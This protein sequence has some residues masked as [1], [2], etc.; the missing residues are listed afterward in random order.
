MGSRCYF[1]LSLLILTAANALG[2]I[3]L[4]PLDLRSLPP[5]SLSTQPTLLVHAFRLRGNT[6]F[7]DAQLQPLLAP[8]IGKRI[9]TEQLEDGRLAL[10]RFYVD[11][12]YINSGAVLSD[13]TV[14][15]G[16]VTY[17][18]IEGRLSDIRLNFVN[19]VGQPTPHLLRDHYVISR[20]RLGS[21]GPLNLI[22]LKDQLE[23]LRQDP[24]IRSIN[25]ELRP[26]LHP[27]KACS[28]CR[29]V[30]AIRTSLEF[31]S[32]IAG[33]RAWEKQAARSARFRPRSDRAWRSALDPL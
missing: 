21:N 6:V 9:T 23:L 25:A 7:S 13:Q 14:T 28:I 33:R 15:D 18:I 26:E 19:D 30:R 3:D 27:D 24:N 29:F 10:T 2:G 20:A 8:Y 4:P 1:G 5:N 22:R 31:S 32:A 17:D 16:I 12:G 11:R